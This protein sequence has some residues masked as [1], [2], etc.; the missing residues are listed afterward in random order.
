M[1]LSLVGGLLAAVLTASVDSSLKAGAPLTC[2]AVGRASR[3]VISAAEASRLTSA[4][5]YFHAGDATTDY[6][7]EMRS[8]SDGSL[9]AYLPGPL[10]ATSAI[11]YR[12][13]GT[14]RAGTTTSTTTYN[15]RVNEACGA[16]RASAQESA[17]AS[18][19]VVGQ[20][21][22]NQPLVPEGFQCEGI[23]SLLTV[24]GDLVANTGCRGPRD[25]RTAAGGAVHSGTKGALDGTAL[26]S[27]VVR[28]V[29][30]SRP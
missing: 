3:V 5:V 28:P 17:Y 6:Y 7:V 18:N 24:G 27:V 14:D 23:A 2:A 26:R 10:A 13:Q 21:S 8:D 12:I 20:T 1:A 11:S 16:E 19:L 4:R 15:V 30:S 22:A 9:F 25:T 29:S